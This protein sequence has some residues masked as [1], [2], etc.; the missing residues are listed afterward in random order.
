MM[1]PLAKITASLGHVGVLEAWQR[2]NCLFVCT[3]Q[4][5]PIIPAIELTDWDRDEAC[6]NT[7]KA[8]NTYDD[9]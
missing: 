7:K 2:A 6:C 1:L 5:D 9:V 4:H 8:S 3:L